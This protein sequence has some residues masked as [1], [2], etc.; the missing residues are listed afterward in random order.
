MS[1]FLP[2]VEKTLLKIFNTYRSHTFLTYCFFVTSQFLADCFATNGFSYILF[3]M[4]ASSDSSP[5]FTLCTCLVKSTSTTTVAAQIFPAA[6]AID[7]ARVFAKVDV[8]NNGAVLWTSL[9][10]LV[11]FGLLLIWARRADKNDQ[12]TVSFLSVTIK[13]KWLSL[14]SM[15]RL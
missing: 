7:F 13:E 10:M 2:Y 8:I 5:A 12:E 15:Y 11:V 1:H 9:S 14:V 4:Q 6:N 3:T